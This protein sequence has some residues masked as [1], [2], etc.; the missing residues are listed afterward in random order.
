LWRFSKQLAMKELHAHMKDVRCKMAIVFATLCFVYVAQ[1]HAVPLPQSKPVHI[2][3]RHPWESGRMM[4]FWLTDLYTK[5]EKKVKA[6]FVRSGVVAFDFLLYHPLYDEIIPSGRRIPFYVDPGDTLIIQVAKNGKVEKYERKHHGSVKYENLL[7]HDISNRLFYTQ[8]DFAEDKKDC[9]F[10]GFVE[11][12]KAKMQVALDSV[13]HVADRYAFSDEERNL[14]CCNVQMQFA[15]W[16]FEYAPM[17]T[18]ELL[19]YASHHEGGWLTTP[20][21]EQESAAIQDLTNYGFLKEMHPDDS[22]YLAS[23]FFP[24][25]IQS[26]EHTQVL[27]YDQYLYSS[28]TPSGLARMDSAYV[29]KD[30]AITQYDHPSLFMDMAMVRRHIEIPAPVD[31][32]SIRLQEVQVIGGTLDQFYRKFGRSE[33][34]PQE[35]VEKVWAPDVNMKGVLS[36]LINHK[37]IRNYKRAKKLI[38]QYGADDAEREALLKA[39][40]SMQKE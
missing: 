5:E 23:R 9:F 15:L 11:K 10:P 20:E 19:A 36:S 14:A 4:Y 37:K 18:S 34:N 12:V 21:Q 8:D 25:F 2:E 30:L 13:N 27:N 17:K 22:T 29:A 6:E 39:W 16:I 24:A 32:G 40:S 38:Q 7:R 35:V 33:Y 1:M 28:D 3:V 31:D 26:Y